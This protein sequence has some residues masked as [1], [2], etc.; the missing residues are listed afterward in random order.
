M[1]MVFII[2]KSGKKFTKA[3][4]QKINAMEKV[5]NIITIKRVIKNTKAIGFKTNTMEMVFIILKVVRSSTKGIGLKTSGIEQVLNIMVKIITTKKKKKVF[6]LKDNSNPV[7]FL[8]RKVLNFC[9]R[10]WSNSKN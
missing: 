5:L 3:N 2:L 4:Y 8:T 6:G 10:I 7:P 1:E 9:P